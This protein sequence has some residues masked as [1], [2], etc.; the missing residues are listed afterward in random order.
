MAVAV[1]VDDQELKRLIDAATRGD[2]AAFARLTQAHYRLVYSL[3]YSAVGDWG[4]AQDIAQDTFLTAWTHL[5]NLRGAGA[6]PMWIRKI[7]RNLALNWIRSAE[8]RRRLAER[9]EQL[10]VPMQEPAEDPAQLLGREERRAAV[11]KALQQLSA[12]VREAMVLFYLE[13]RSGPEAAA[14]LGISEN[15]FKLRLHTGRARLRKYIEEQVEE[16]LYADLAPPDSK[17]AEGRV[18]AGL[19]AG[20]AMPELGRS[21]SGSGAGLWLHHLAHNGIAETVVPILQGGLV[22]NAK[23]I[24]VGAVMATLFAGGAYW[25]CWDGRP[26]RRNTA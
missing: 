4:A 1:I 19:A 22:V 26:R 25:D 11:W 17:S 12:P 9:H 10:V 20:P 24:A 14:Q 16:G 18:L 7:A 15:A 21:V 5:G 8:Y 3:A 13:G 6:F 23:K 2:A